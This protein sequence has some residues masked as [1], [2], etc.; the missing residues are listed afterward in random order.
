[1]SETTTFLDEMLDATP[2]V[3]VSTPPEFNLRI[4]DDKVA[5]LL[6]CPDPHD[7][8]ESTVQR[9]VGGFEGLELPEYP[10]AAFLT[11]VLH[12]ICAPGDHIRDAVLMMG[13]APVEPQHG[14]MDWSRDYFADGW[15]SDEESGAI[16]YWAKLDNKAVT[17][18]E[19]LLVLQPAVSGE[20]GLNVF[21]NKIPV[22]KPDKVRV[23]C[24]KGVI[25]E[26]IA[27]EVRTFTAEISG[28]VR[29]TD[30]TLSV[31]DVYIIK[32][33]VSL[34]T[35]NIRHTGTLQIDGDVETGAS[36]EADGDVMVKGMLEPCHIRAGGALTVNGGIVG[37]PE[38]TITVGGDLAAKYIKDAVIRAG[39]HVRVSN[40]I[41]HCDIETRGKVDASRGRIAGGR[42]VARMGITVGEAGAS[43][44]SRTLLVAGVD[45]T[46]EV[47]VT[48]KKEKLRQME[49]A[50]IKLRGAV[51]SLNR[52]PGGLNDDETT[53]AAGLDRKARALGQ[54]VADGELELRRLVND[55]MTGAREEIFMLR[56]CWAGTT[57]QLGEY[58]TLVRSSILKPR[59]VKRFKTRVRVV[60][61]GDGNAPD[62][63]D[64]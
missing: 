19:V 64:D 28:R 58:K 55:A 20:A 43:G 13:Q 3:D 30:N 36:I 25:E 40:E 16:N 7:D 31:D 38:Y 22:D 39:G 12:N 2:E 1:M 57:V 33:N 48:E 42:T 52:K 34:E 11:Q 62:E 14:R 4:S 15:E 10:D 6:D 45:P 56:E 9:I 17:A 37:G 27:D 46:L 24:G 35:G 61:M 47:I 41:T 59:L 5:V 29:F 63:D 18:G 54:G 51:D 44:S 8:L 21:G 60:P 49:K 23:R 32:G 53:L 50:R 26:E